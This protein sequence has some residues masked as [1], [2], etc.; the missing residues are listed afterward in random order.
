MSN[1]AIAIAG[2]VPRA[3]TCCAYVTH[4]SDLKEQ[5]TDTLSLISI[6]NV[7]SLVLGAFRRSLNYVLLSLERHRNDVIHDRTSESNI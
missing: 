1:A 2:D 7:P 5:T 6:Y 4:T 3:D